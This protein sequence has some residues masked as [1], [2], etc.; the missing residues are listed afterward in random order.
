M[1]RLLAFM[2]LFL[3]SGSFLVSSCSKDDDDNTP[4]NPQ[5]LITTVELT[6]TDAL[7]NSSTF[8]ARDLDGDGGNPPVVDDITLEDNTVYTVTAR[9]LDERD[10]GDVE[11]ITVEVREEDLEHLVCYLFG[12]DPIFNT[13]IQQDPDSNGDP[14]GLITIM[15]TSNPGSG[16]LRIS[17]KHEPDKSTAD[18]CSTGE[19]DVEVDYDVTIQ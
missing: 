19:T 4:D 5:E 18:R 16:F 8:I 7:G 10:P 17:L 12:G 13:N 6:F 15:S 9:F 1:N 3:L 11:D 14:L 2:F